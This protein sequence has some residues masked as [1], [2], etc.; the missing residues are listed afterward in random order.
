MTNLSILCIHIHVM[1]PVVTV[2]TIIHITYVCASKNSLK[3][4]LT[5]SV[6]IHTNVMYAVRSSCTHSFKCI[7]SLFS[8]KLQKTLKYLLH[9]I[10]LY[11][12]KNIFMYV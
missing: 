7:L 1:V 4:E 2:I 8:P 6:I 12:C 9:Y 5:A 11:I 3:V 10:I